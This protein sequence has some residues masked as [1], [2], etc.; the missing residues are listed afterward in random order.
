[1]EENENKLLN[2]WLS[3]KYDVPEEKRQ[4]TPMLFIGDDVLIGTEATFDNLLS[5]IEKYASTGAEPTW[6]DFEPEQAEET[7]VE[8]FERW[9]VLIIL[10]AG[11]VDGLNPCAFATLVFFISYMAFTGRRGRDILFVGIAFALGVFL[12]YLLV[13]VGL[14]KLFQSLEFFPK[15]GRWMYLIT[16]LLCVILAVFT[17]R[18]FFRA[19]QGQASE[20]TLKLPTRMRKWINRVIRESAQARAFVVMALV[21]GFVVSLIELTCTGQ[22]YFPTIQF[23][24]TVPELASRAFF[25]LVLY[26]LMFIAPL[27]VVFMLSYFGTTSEQMGLFFARHTANVKLATALTFVGLALWMTWTLAPLFSL[28]APM[29]W[30]ALGVVVLVIGIGVVILRKYEDSPSRTNRRR[31][32]K[33][34]SRVKRRG[35][36]KQRR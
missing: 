17:I 34:Q 7:I 6:D 14:L 18:D 19:R 22:V 29:N 8:R 28:A 23:V 32:Q 9:G 35:K 3:G 15:L 31:Q 36:K 16:A 21:T 30:I 33:A 27:A 11:L 4:S 24:L 1:M 2:E 20:M 26:C 13:G 12:T 10:G 5:A 25:Y